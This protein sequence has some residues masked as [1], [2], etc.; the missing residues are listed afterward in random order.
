MFRSRRNRVLVILFALGGLI[1]ATSSSWEGDTPN[2][3]DAE[4]AH[5]SLLAEAEGISTE[6]A[7]ERYAWQSE[8]AALVDDIRHDYPDD[9][10]GARIEGDTTGWVAF[11]GAAPASARSEI[12]R[13]PKAITIIENRGFTEADLAERLIAIHHHTMDK[14]EVDKA[15]SSYDI[16][17]GRFEIA[18]ELATPATTPEEKATAIALISADPPSSF[19]VVADRI[20]YEV[21]D[22][23]SGG[24][25]EDVNGGMHQSSCTAG[26]VIKNGSTRNI[27]TAGHCTNN[28]DLTDPTLDED[29]PLGGA[30]EHTSREWGDLQRHS[31]PGGHTGVNEYRYN[32][33]SNA[34]SDVTA[35][36]TPA[37]GQYLTK[38]GKSSGRTHDHVYRLN[39]SYP[40]GDRLVAMEHR[41]AS[42]GDSG[43]PWFAGTTAYGVHSGRWFIGLAMRDLFTPAHQIDDAFPG[44]TV[45]TS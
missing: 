2:V 6:A 41:R 42:G 29:I 33:G 32:S 25:D 7:I 37:E 39:V 24:Y 9:F 1:A 16:S 34:F 15:I 13:F 3:S 40:E 18:V 26:W 36:G 10:A 19:A 31:I 35:V 43:G 5:W 4:R 27:V 20:D 8:F 38:Y 17:T 45:L 21:V 23:L 28:I 30:I 12:D 44:W 11:S 22:A 14:S